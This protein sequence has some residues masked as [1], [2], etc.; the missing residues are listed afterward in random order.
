MD[1][2]GGE[3]WCLVI[4]GILHYSQLELTVIEAG[5]E[6]KQLEKRGDLHEVF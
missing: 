4:I 1:E 3:N 5:R 6:E 2:T